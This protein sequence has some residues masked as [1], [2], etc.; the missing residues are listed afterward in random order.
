MTVVSPL[1]DN[2]HIAVVVSMLDKKQS[3]FLYSTEANADHPGT[4]ELKSTL[5][6]HML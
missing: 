5:C 3:V 2:G 1:D 4:T 6:F